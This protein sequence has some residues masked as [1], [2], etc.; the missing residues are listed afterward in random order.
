MSEKT[1]RFKQCLYITISEMFDVT[2][3]NLFT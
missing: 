3:C 1:E 2:Q